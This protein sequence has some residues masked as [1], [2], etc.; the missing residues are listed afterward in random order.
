MILALF[1]NLSGFLRRVMRL[2]TESEKA[3]REK[4][5]SKSLPEMP[6]TVLCIWLEQ[7]LLKTMQI[8]D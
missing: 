1:L 4:R 7:K 3:D 6:F 5:N 8:I 2:Y